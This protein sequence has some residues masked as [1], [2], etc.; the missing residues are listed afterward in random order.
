MAWLNNGESTFLWVVGWESRYV[1]RYLGL[2]PAWSWLPRQFRAALFRAKWSRA[3][4]N[5][6]IGVP[7]RLR[8]LQVDK[9]ARKRPSDS[10]DV[11]TLSSSPTVE[12]SRSRPS[13]ATQLAGTSASRIWCSSPSTLKTA[14]AGRSSASDSLRETRLMWNFIPCARRLT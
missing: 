2:T 12:C 7:E 4:R 8:D 3:C 13:Y 14:A 1:S 10:A 9:R 11:S 5:R 6:D